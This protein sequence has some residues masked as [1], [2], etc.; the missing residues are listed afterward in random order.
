MQT[1][2]C[3]VISNK[4]IPLFTKKKE[5]FLNVAW[6]GYFMIHGYQ[7][8]ALSYLYAADFF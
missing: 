8:P 4:I 5:I 2:H 1:S 6:K 3:N 7:G